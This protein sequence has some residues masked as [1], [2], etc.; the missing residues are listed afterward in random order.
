MRTS[1]LGAVLVLLLV[2][3]LAGGCGKSA[4]PEAGP[5]GPPF[6]YVLEGPAKV[7]LFGTIHVPDPRIRDLPPSVTTAHAASDVVLGE[8]GAD[9][10]SDVKA[11]IKQFLP[12]GKRL[13]DVVPKEVL[14]RLRAY[15]KARGGNSSGLE[16]LK[17][18]WAAINVAL[19]DML[20]LMAQ[21]PPMDT[22]FQTDAKA[23]GKEHGGLETVSEQIALFNGLSY[24][25]QAK[26]LDR[27]LA[28]LEKAR[29]AGGNPLDAIVVPYYRGDLDAL[30]TEMA[31]METDADPDLKAFGHALI[32]RRNHIMAERLLARIAAAPGKTWFVAVGAGHLPGPEGLLA[33]L[34]KQG[35]TPRRATREERFEPAAV[36]AATVPEPVPTR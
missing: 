28:D 31:R 20:P 12:Q 9:E 5:P 30:A 34:E 33:L 23:A 36:P 19:I 13:G 22:T 29:D 7:F 11:A 4:V 3:G 21:H 15:M 8:L 14:E 24:E 26:F 35:Y 10:M 2:V 16:R 27:T 18:I 1:R 32:T 17:P 25:V 6:L